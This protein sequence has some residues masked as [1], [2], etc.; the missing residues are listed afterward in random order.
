VDHHHIRRRAGLETSYAPATVWG[1]FESAPA[2]AR[3]QSDLSVLDLFCG[4]GGLTS[5]FHEAG[6]FSTV[7]AVEMDPVA[8]ASFEATFGERIVRVASIGAWLEEDDVPSVDVVVGGPP[9]QGFSTLGRQD[10]EDVR[11]ELWRDYARTIVR[12]EPRYF[13]LENVGAFMASRQ[14][15]DL[16]GAASAG[17]VLAA[18]DF[19]V[20]VLNAADF[21]AAQARRRTIVIG[22]HRDLPATGMPTPTHAGRHVPLSAAFRYVRREVTRTELPERHV[23]VAGR[24]QPGR[25]TTRELHIGRT[26]TSTSIARI[27]SIPSGGNR[28]DIPLHLRPACWRSHTSGSMDVMGRLR[29]DRPSVTIRTEFWKPEKGRYLHPTED[30]ALTHFEAARIQGFPDEHRWVGSK[31]A[32]GRQIGNAVPIPMGR[33]IAAHLAAQ[34]R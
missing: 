1:V 18:Y 14:L 10:V 6:G 26:Y 17:G 20:A 11:N 23:V 9:C 13:V 31:A 32:I 2:P 34:P 15:A 16:R 8:A 24:T 28:F 4:A 33:A 22:R 25:F 7:R 12:A 5:G 29:L 21:G 30:R 27:R 19:E 3:Q